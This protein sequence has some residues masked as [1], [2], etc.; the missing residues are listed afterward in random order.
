MPKLTSATEALSKLAKLLGRGTQEAAPAAAA[1]VEKPAQYAI[2]KPNG[3]IFGAPFYVRAAA[4]HI[5]ENLNKEMPGHSV[6]PVPVEQMSPLDHYIP[7]GQGLS[8]PA[9][10]QPGPQLA[11]EDIDRIMQQSGGGKF[12]DPTQGMAEG[13]EFDPVISA[14]ERVSGQSS[15]GTPGVSGAIKDAVDALKSW[16]ASQ[17]NELNEGRQQ[18]EDKYVNAEDHATGGTTGVSTDHEAGLAKRFGVRV[19]QQAYGLDKDGNPA[20]GGRAW[21]EGQGGTPLGFLDEIASVPHNLLSLAKTTRGLADRGFA[22]HMPGY[23]ESADSMFD[24]IDP[25]WS[26][27]AADRLDR[28]QQAMNRE[29]G[30]GEAHT[31]PEH[32][33]D[34][35]ASLVSPIPALG[36]GKT[37]GAAG[38]LLEMTTPLRPRTLKNFATDTALMGGAGAGIDALTQRLSRLQAQAPQGGGT[39]VDPASFSQDMGVQPELPPTGNI[40]NNHQMVPLVGDDGSIVYGVDPKTFAKGGNVRR[41]L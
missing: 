20:L 22:K 11:P 36:E 1:A 32:L 6:Q 24:A 40:H 15:P 26:R 7:R 41:S 14:R 3:Q 16:F 23:Q 31:L 8:P 29:H 28:L 33:T 9:P 17:R 37:A 27:D 25:Q 18:V 4:N 30:V 2:I 12:Q 21:T 5:A 34:A 39:P 13:G 19:M 10:T 38:R 35:A